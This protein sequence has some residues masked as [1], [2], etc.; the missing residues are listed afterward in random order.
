MF[1]NSLILA[2]SSSIDSLGIGITYG[3]KNTRISYM[4]K[5]VLFVILFLISF[6]SV[7]FGDILKNIK[8]HYKRLDIVKPL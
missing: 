6:L 7:C 3:I 4:A 5:I 2:L 1:I 8:E